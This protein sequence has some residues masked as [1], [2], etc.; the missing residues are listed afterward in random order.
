VSNQVVFG[1]EELIAKLKSLKDGVSAGLG[2][3]ALAGAYVLEGFVKQSMNEG[4]HGRIYRRGGRVHQASAPGEPPAID[5]GNLLNSINS[6]LVEA[7]AEFAVAEVGTNAEYAPPLEY[8]TATMAARP[9]MRPA[10]DEHEGEI[11]EAMRK[12]IVRLVNEAIP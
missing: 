4:H 5:F 12:T 10:T 7:S 1:E 11:A 2:K 6:E 3:A 9:F 8:G